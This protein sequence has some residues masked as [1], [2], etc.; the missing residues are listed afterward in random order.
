V[1]A[2]LLTSLTT[3]LLVLPLKLLTGPLGKR[4]T[5]KWKYWAWLALSLRLLIPV[6]VAAP[7]APIRIPAP[8]MRIEIPRP[9]APE[10]GEAAARPGPDVS[11]E[12]P[13]AAAP[14]ETVPTASARTWGEWA[15]LI[16]LPGAVCLAGYH[17]L[18]YRLLRRRVLRWS[19]PAGG[20]A[21]GVTYARLA[22]EMGIKKPPRLYIS[23]RAA[24]PLL[25]GLVRPVIVLPR[26][27]DSE[28]EA[29][30]VLRHE[31]THHRRHDVWYKLLLLA[32]GVLHWFNPLV[33]LMRREAAEDLELVC[34]RE[35]TRDRSFAEKQEYG[36]I[37][38][39]TA[40]E[41]RTDS[42]MST[43]FPGSEK[44]LRRRLENLLAGRKKAGVIPFCAFLLL[45]GMM[46]TLVACQPV[47]PPRGDVNT[48]PVIDAVQADQVSDNITPPVSPIGP[49]PAPVEKA[50]S[51]FPRK[52]PSLDEDVVIET[53]RRDIEDFFDVS[54]E[55]IPV[56]INDLDEFVNEGTPK[57]MVAFF[58]EDVNVRDDDTI[59]VNTVLYDATIELETRT[60]IELD[61]LDHRA[62]TAAD[63]SQ[64]A[65]YIAAAAAVAR[66]KLSLS[67]D[68][69]TAV[70]YL[71]YEPLSRKKE[72]ADNFFVRVVFPE[73]LFY[74]EISVADMS[75]LC[76]RFFSDAD[77]LDAYLT[78][79]SVMM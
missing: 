65:D 26:G 61:S 64:T 73:D 37:I 55:G 5:P 3:G 59:A 24:G 46:G 23:H 45:L 43:S 50:Q 1:A 20:C 76:Y 63:A 42:A 22:E 10:P 58:S 17:I 75:P 52:L 71:P 13:A 41:K 38:L 79:D 9:A 21:A 16:W 72:I 15:G 60:I 28:A 7:R 78:R 66:D 11:A 74:V 51:E 44:T 57:R 35:T 32:V 8:E 34:D 54:L 40:A 6:A 19:V 47:T 4:Y 18:G 27:D 49:P 30:L 68:G 14:A 69:A 67:P 39:K 25:I 53:V 56:Y 2:L 12:R 36:G 77:G 62:K 29:R 33:Y 70:C 31:L 48:P